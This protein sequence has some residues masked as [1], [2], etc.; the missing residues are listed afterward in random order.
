M[1]HSRQ[2][3]AAEHCGTDG[4]GSCPI[5]TVEHDGA[6]PLRLLESR[7]RLRALLWAVLVVGGIVTAGPTCPF[8]VDN[9]KL[10]VV[11][12]LLALMLVAIASLDP[13]FQGDVHVPPDAF[14]YALQNFEEPPL[15][16]W[17]GQGSGRSNRA[18]K[19]TNY[20]RP[21][22]RVASKVSS[23]PVVTDISLVHGR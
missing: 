9:F 4:D 13:P 8:A 22:D 19:V 5:G 11:Q 3:R 17:A 21:R 16:N 14:G 7:E 12:V 6:S 10:H 23:E 20:F 18:H 15:P 1:A 2:R